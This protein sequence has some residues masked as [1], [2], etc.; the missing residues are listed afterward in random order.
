ME[1]QDEATFGLSAE[2][3]LSITKSK[4]IALQREILKIG[5]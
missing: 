3:K 4:G 2:Q 5:Y 1:L